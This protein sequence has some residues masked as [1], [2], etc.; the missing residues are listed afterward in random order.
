MGVMHF[1]QNAIELDSGSGKIFKSSNT[2]LIEDGTKLTGKNI[3]LANGSYAQ[4][5]IDQVPALRKSIPT[6]L[7]GIGAGIDLI[8]PKWVHEYGGLGREIFDLKEVVRTTDRGGA[9]GVHLVPYGNGQFYAGSSSLTSLDDDT[10]P[11][12]HGV[13]VL[14]HALVYEIHRTFFSTGIRL[15]GNGFRPTSADCFPLIGETDQ[16]GIWLLNGT[17]R[18]GFTMSPYVSQQLASAILGEKTTLPEMFKPCRSLISYKTKAEALKDAELMYVGADFQHGG[19]QVPYM[20]DKYNEMRRK[21]ITSFYERRSL[22]NFG[23]HPELI[24]LY[25]NDKFFKRIDHKRMPEQAA[26]PLT[27]RLT[28]LLKRKEQLVSP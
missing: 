11:K 13:H 18:D 10:E 25:E 4:T 15:R 24:H 26:V 28:N 17:K 20:V 2:V 6:L 12:L 22:D 14:L 5:L 23:I 1:D 8:F 9:C 21:E 16:P 3:V 19:V 7:F 27:D